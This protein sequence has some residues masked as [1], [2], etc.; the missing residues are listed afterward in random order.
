M[1][2]SSSLSSFATDTGS[3]P[4]TIQSP[5]DVPP[6]GPTPPEVMLSSLIN[7]IGSKKEL[8]SRFNVFFVLAYSVF[9]PS[10]PYLLAFIGGVAIC[11]YQTFFEKSFKIVEKRLD[12]VLML[13]AL[14]GLRELSGDLTSK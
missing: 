7:A 3:I 9:E 5:A 8:L 13:S 11:I 2:R 6:F 1:S 12:F 14:V 10:Y 4:P